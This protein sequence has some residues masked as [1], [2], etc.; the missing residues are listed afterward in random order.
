MLPQIH[1]GAV[2]SPVLNRQPLALISQISF[3]WLLSCAIYYLIHSEKQRVTSC[4]DMYLLGA[5]HSTSAVKL[6]AT[7]QTSH[8]QVFLSC[9]EFKS[10]SSHLYVCTMYITC[11]V[12]HSLVIQGKFGRKCIAAD[13]RLGHVLTLF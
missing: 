12:Q 2:Q 5:C 9:T 8:H 1:T 6:L 7:H 10:F 4:A 11:T 3:C 13:S